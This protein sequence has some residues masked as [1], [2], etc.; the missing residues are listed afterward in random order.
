MREANQCYSPLYQHI[1]EAK[2]L[3]FLSDERAKKAIYNAMLYFEKQGDENQLAQLRHNYGSANLFHCEL[4]NAEKYLKMAYHYYRDK[5]SVWV[6][7]A[8]NNLAMIHILKKEYKEA[9]QILQQPYPC[10]TELFTEVTITCNIISCYLKL[11]QIKAAKDCF[12]EIRD[13]VKRRKNEEESL[14]IG[15]YL[16]I[17]EAMITFHDGHRNDACRALEK[18]EIPNGYEFIK[19]FIIGICDT[20][21]K[22]KTDYQFP[23]I[24]LF[25]EQQIYLCD[26]LFI[27]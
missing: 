22:I 8:Y 7:Y 13:I 15:I 17:M 6:A 2:S 27:E 20:E 26:L 4:E 24:R 14:Y 5:G 3:I 11:N 21:K 18:I 16:K 25:V 10:D 1:L 19:E 23:Y 12:I 9:L